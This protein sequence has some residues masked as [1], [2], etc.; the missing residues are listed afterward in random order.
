[1]TRERWQDVRRL[2]SAALDLKQEERPAYLDRACAGDHSLRREVE[3]LLASGD[4]IRN[5]FLQRP[6]RELSGG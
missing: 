6:S 5:S 2:L 3:S 1:M 4:D